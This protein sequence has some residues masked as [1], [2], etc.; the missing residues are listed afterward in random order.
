MRQLSIRHEVNSC[1]DIWPPLHN[2]RGIKPH[3]TNGNETNAARRENCIDFLHTAT[4]Q[5]NS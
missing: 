1:A 5:D 2:L 4:E 3:R